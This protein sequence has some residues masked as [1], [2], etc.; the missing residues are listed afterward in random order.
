MKECRRCEKKFKYEDAVDV[1]AVEFSK[2]CKACLAQKAKEQ[3][4]SEG[5]KS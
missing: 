2:V 5:K 1:F 4:E 3:K